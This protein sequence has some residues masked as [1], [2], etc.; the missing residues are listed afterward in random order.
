MNI[1]VCYTCTSYTLPRNK[2]NDIVQLYTFTSLTKY[3]C[4]QA[5]ICM[6]NCYSWYI[7]SNLIVLIR[8]FTHT[9][10]KSMFLHDD[11]M[12]ICI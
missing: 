6:S 3:E 11:Y 7:D 2:V 1:R 8:R 4:L 10:I 12:M 5:I 9:N